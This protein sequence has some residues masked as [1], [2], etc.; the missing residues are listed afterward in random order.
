MA[1][2]EWPLASERR[3]KTRTS[4]AR[5]KVSSSSSRTTASTTTTRTTGLSDISKISSSLSQNLSSTSLTS[6]ILDDDARRSLQPFQTSVLTQVDETV[7]GGAASITKD[8]IIEGVLVRES[9]A[10][11]DGIG[12]RTQ[13]LHDSDLPID[14]NSG[15]GDASGTDHSRNVST[16][17]N[18]VVEAVLVESGRGSSG[19][20]HTGV[21]EAASNVSPE[22]FNA[23][24]TQQAEV[25]GSSSRKITSTSFKFQKKEEPLQSQ[26][27]QKQTS[28]S[29]SEQIRGSPSTRGLDPVVEATGVSSS[30]SSTNHLV[31]RQQRSASL[32]KRVTDQ[33]PEPED[34]ED[35]CGT[36]VGM[37]ASASP[38]SIGE[39]ICLQES[40]LDEDLVSS[41]FQAVGKLDSTVLTL[42][43]EDSASPK[44]VDITEA[45]EI[46]LQ[47]GRNFDDFSSTFVMDC[48]SDF[49]FIVDNTR[50]RCDITGVTSAPGCAGSSTGSSTSSSSSTTSAKDEQHHVDGH[51]V[52]WSSPLYPSD[53]ASRPSVAVNY[54][55]RGGAGGRGRPPSELC[56]SRTS[57]EEVLIGDGGSNAAG[58]MF[59]GGNDVRASSDM[60]SDGL[61]GY[62]YSTAQME[63]ARS[64]SSSFGVQ[65]HPGVQVRNAKSRPWY[66]PSTHLEWLAEKAH[67]LAAERSRMTGRGPG[68]GSGRALEYHLRQQN[69]SDYDY[70]EADKEGGGQEVS[71]GSPQKRRGRTSA[72]RRGREEHTV[73]SERQSSTALECSSKSTTEVETGWMGG[74]LMRILHL[75]YLQTRYLARTRPT[76]VS[77]L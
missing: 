19:S 10:P 67:A 13:Q 57:V 9:N 70:G 8:S 64:S 49:A 63:A 37:P 60:R 30:N 36:S 53:F 15:G 72:E 23:T 11:V 42:G 71:Q 2:V 77:Y 3:P 5:K 74:L 76:T 12:S 1:F 25:D 69:E 33:Q 59:G 31:V 62:D 35:D 66:L 4:R 40:L 6:S 46:S 28:S 38:L 48:S 24:T 56:I 55:A 21:E 17:A 26:T 47:R 52:S 16:C 43:G 73:G 41:L 29:S 44:I 65:V 7:S 75:R 68:E 32:E 14:A 20:T 22:R 58:T 34:D 27:G 18:V 61:F 50:D 54:K 45:E 39:D 51:H